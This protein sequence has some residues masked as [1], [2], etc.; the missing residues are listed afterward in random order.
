MNGSLLGDSC[1]DTLKS[2]PLDSPWTANFLATLRQLSA[3]APQLPLPGNALRWKDENFHL[4][5]AVSLAFPASEIAS[6]T[7]QAEQLAIKLFSLGVWGPQGPL[8]LHLSELALTRLQQQDSALIDFIDLFHHRS[9][10][11]FFRAWYAAQDTASLDR[12]ESDRFSYYLRCL[13]GLPLP[14]TPQTK[15]PLLSAGFQLAR[16][17]CAPR[18]LISTLNALFHLPFQIAEFQSG[19]ISLPVEERCQLA[20]SCRVGVNAML[21]EASYQAGY[22]FKIGCGPLSYQQYRS[23][24]PDNDALASISRVIQRLTGGHYYFD[25][26]LTLASSSS[27]PTTLSGEQQLGFDTWLVNDAGERPQQGMIY[28][29]C[30]SV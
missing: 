30:V 25:I 2:L 22:R 23:L 17:T 14:T 18:D 3:A 6:I 4:S 20:H 21:G 13:S 11:I 12:P 26:Q 19:W 7:W 8:P 9:M 29:A 16:K 24:H 1:P 15:H 27:F 28:T 10:A 5:Q